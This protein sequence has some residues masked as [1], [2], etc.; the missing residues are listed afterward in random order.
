MAGIAGLTGAVGGDHAVLVDGIA[1]AMVYRQGA[2]VETWSDA[3][4]GLCRVRSG[5]DNPAPQPVA[6]ADGTRR[7]VLFGECFGYE[8]HRAE[9]ATQGVCFERADDD[10]EYCLQLLA[11]GG[12]AAL[13]GLSG[14]FC[15][16]HYDCRSREL[17]LANDRLGTRPLFFATTPNGG[18]AFATQLSALLTLPGMSR[19]LDARAAVEFCALQRV[20][21]RKTYHQGIEVLPPASVLRWRDGRVTITPYWKL[22][23][24]PKP[25][26]ADEYAEELAAVLQRAVAQ[27]SRRGARVAMLLSGGLDARMVVAAS[28]PGLECIS[29]GDYMNPEVEAAAKVARA[30]GFGFRFLQRG[31]DHYP[32]LLDRAVDIGH[33]MHPFNHA[34]AIGF[35]EDLAEQFDV[36]THGYVPELMFRGSSLPK[37]ER[38]RA[39]VVAGE[40]LDRSLNAGNLQQRVFQRG[41]S[42]LKLGVDRLL[43]PQ[44]AALLQQTL[45]EDAREMAEAAAQ[46][47]EDVFD[48]F[49]WPDVYY[50]GRYPS[51]LF[52]HSLRMFMTERSLVFHNEV[53]DLHL[54]MP[55]ELRCD[56]TVW[57][58]AVARLDKRVAAVVNANTGH[59]PFMPALLAAG[60]DAA[61][62]LA[63]RVPGMWRLAQRSAAAEPPPGASPISWPRFDW[64]VR[65]NAELRRRVVETLADAMALPPELFDLRQV[66]ALLQEHLANR[67]QHRLVLFVLL[68]F[69]L[70]HRRHLAGDASV[71]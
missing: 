39:G 37:V 69:G 52:E 29:F 9:L 13:A 12:D 34:H 25:G 6:S 60:L 27:I 64:L 40:E 41:Y 10:A 47:S 57:M 2:A 53:I 48:H 22:R 32:R 26:T 7:L 66:D 30:R 33:G 3:Q 70:W 45:R 43:Q 67:G 21:G 62:E 49:L 38:R 18:L 24:A 14:S 44:A 23:Y 46:A 20:L 17:T 11:H 71:A 16:A 8:P 1:R 31:H 58:K 5:Y 36:V 42:L 15:L 4:A 63:E 59:S 65:D 35:V 19:T 54:R 68:T 56:S 28:G 61:G 51:M 50:H 55:L